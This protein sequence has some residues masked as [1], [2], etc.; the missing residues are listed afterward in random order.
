MQMKGRHSWQ[1]AWYV[2][3]EAVGGSWEAICTISFGDNL[4]SVGSHGLRCQNRESTTKGIGLI[5]P[6]PGSCL[7]VQVFKKP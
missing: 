5:Y 1:K 6:L 2:L 4:R 7:R 3:W